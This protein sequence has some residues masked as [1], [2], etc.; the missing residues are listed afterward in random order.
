MDL[1]FYNTLSQKIETFTPIDKTNKTVGMYCCGPTVYNFAHIGNF[2]TF[3]FSDLIRRVLEFK[4]YKVRHV[5]NITDVDDKIIQQV[6]THPKKISIGE[7]TKRYEDEFFKDFDSLNC[8]RPTITPK[9]TEYVG[10]M[11]KIIS[12]LI[13]NGIAYSAYDGSIYFNVKKYINFGGNYNNLTNFYQELIN[14]RNIIHPDDY[15]KNSLGIENN[16][17][18]ALWKARVKKD[19]EIF[20]NSPWG[21]GR[22]GWHIECT[23]MSRNLL[24]EFFDLHVGGE[25]LIFPHHENEIAQSEGLGLGNNN[26]P[27]KFVNYW[28]HIS[29][30]LSE[31]RKMSKSDG[32]F[33]TLKDLF[34]QGFVGR[35]IRYL[36]LTTH[37]KEPLNFTIRGLHGARAALS[38]LD[39]CLYRLNEIKG[40]TDS[41]TIFSDIVDKFDNAISNDFNLSKAWSVIFDWVYD[42]NKK[43]SE[44][45]ISNIEA[46]NLIYTWKHIN[47]V[48]GIEDNKIENEIPNKILL[49]L[50]KRN[51]ARELKDYALSDTIRKELNSLGWTIEDTALGSRVKKINN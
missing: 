9:A 51:K 17:D 7:Y 25:D 43:I 45:K 39:G 50:E 47:S 18:F 40:N 29:H 8:I 12:K 16:E 23:A 5:M 3:V 38:R 10:E 34:D 37:Y 32:N 2:R 11:I 13:E 24:G 27:T 41:Y 42:I 46:A 30:L 20:W 15:G 36:L 44:D 35:E 49:L 6:N 19:G 26:R 48:F 22:P 21:E 4:G 14:F 28:F 33:Y 1:K 31:G